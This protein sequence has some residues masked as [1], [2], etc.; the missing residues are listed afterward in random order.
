MGAQVKITAKQLSIGYQH[1][2]EETIVASGLDCSL[3]GGEFV[4]LLGPN[5][6]GKSTLIR[7]LGWNAETI[8]G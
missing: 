5:G 4:C 3:H 8:G 7:T 1:S 2:A 6:A